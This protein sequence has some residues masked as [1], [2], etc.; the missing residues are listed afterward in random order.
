MGPAAQT[1]FD[2]TQ[3]DPHYTLS[4][5]QLPRRGSTA[6]CDVYT[7]GTGNDALVVFFR[8]CYPRR[9][10]TVVGGEFSEQRIRTLRE[11][12]WRP[13]YCNHYYKRTTHPCFCRLKP[14]TVVLSRGRR[15]RVGWR[16]ISAFFWCCLCLHQRRETR[17]LT[18]CLTRFLM[19]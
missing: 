1:R 15:A 12:T 16:S 8:L 4:Q 9:V 14:E 6:A 2:R 7:S 17:C 13:P 10:Y 3:N 19:C 5:S 18:R 11:N